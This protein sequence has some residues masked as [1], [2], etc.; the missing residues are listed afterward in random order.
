MWKSPHCTAGVATERSMSASTWLVAPAV[1]V[2][3]RRTSSY[4]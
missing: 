4:S 3:V 2:I 1:T